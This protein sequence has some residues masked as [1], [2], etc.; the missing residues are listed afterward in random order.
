MA[1]VIREQHYNG[2]AIANVAADL[3]ADLATVPAALADTAA[4]VEVN[5][6]L[7][8]LEADI[9]EIA[10]KV[11]FILDALRDANVIAD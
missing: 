11:N 3:V 5:G 10:T 4:R 6:R 7:T 8:I 1:I 9:S 2:A